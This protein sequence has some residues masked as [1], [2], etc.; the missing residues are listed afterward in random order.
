MFSIKTQRLLVIYLLVSKRLFY[1]DSY[2][3]FKLKPDIEDH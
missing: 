3:E 1:L 2:K